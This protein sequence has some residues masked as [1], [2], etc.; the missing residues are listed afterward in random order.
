MMSRAA[1]LG[2]PCCRVMTRRTLE[3]LAV[4]ISPSFRFFTGTLRRTI[5]VC[6]TSHNALIFIW[7][8]AASVRVLSAL[9]KSID[10]V[11][12]LKS[13]RCATSFLA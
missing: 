11:D 10:A 4:S 3:P 6:R 2:I 1:S 8:S 9:L 7:S 12:P 5:R 13:Y